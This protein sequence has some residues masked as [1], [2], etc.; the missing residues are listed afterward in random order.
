MISNWERISD[1]IK[2]IIV[3]LKLKKL[4]SAVILRY[5]RETFQMINL[6]EAYITWG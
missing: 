6:I 3:K 2:E 4:Y 1:E 5:D